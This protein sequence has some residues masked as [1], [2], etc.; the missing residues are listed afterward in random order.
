MKE[1]CSIPSLHISAEKGCWLRDTEGNRYLDGN[2]SIWTNA[3]GHNDPDLNRVLLD[4]VGKVS[5]TTYLGLSHPAGAE[6]GRR[7]V[8]AQ[9]WQPDSS[10][11]QR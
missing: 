10:V 1:Y 5:H 11:V 8:E 7:L 4:R 6:L 9:S 2:A 3:L